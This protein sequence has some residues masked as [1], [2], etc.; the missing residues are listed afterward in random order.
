MN[1]LDR[2]KSN[3]EALSPRRPHEHTFARVRPALL[4]HSLVALRPA[5]AAHCGL[6]LR[7]RRLSLALA[8]LGAL[9]ALA[10][11]LEGRLH[12][13]LPLARQHETLARAARRLDLVTKLL[14]EVGSAER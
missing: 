12:L 8:L 9:D 5:E 6:R 1:R 13:V 14:H 10:T 2:R 7:R 4:R 11:P 3:P